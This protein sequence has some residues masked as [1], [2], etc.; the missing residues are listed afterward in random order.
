MY[1]HLGQDTTVSTK[2][3]VGIFD[4][5]TTTISKK[6][7]DFLSLAQR[8][9]RVVNTSMELPK[10]FVLEAGKSQRVYIC[11][12]SAATLKKR[13]QILGKNARKIHKKMV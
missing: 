12:L 11:Q 4:L 3:I 8:E 6:T 1:L 10:S 7:R 2:D 5:D 9:N 13:V